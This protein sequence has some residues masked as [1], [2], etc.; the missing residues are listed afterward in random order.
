[1]HQKR[2]RAPNEIRSASESNSRP[3]GLSAPPMRATRPS[4]KSK[5]HAARMKYSATQMS[6]NTPVEMSASTTLVNATKPQKR[7]P[8]VNRFGRK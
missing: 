5:M 2:R 7:L 3:N 4:N 8:A 1:M 6:V